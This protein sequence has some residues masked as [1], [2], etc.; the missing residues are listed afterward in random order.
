MSE[1]PAYYQ[2]EDRLPRHPSL[3]HLRNESRELQRRIRAGEP[4]ALAELA[5]HH[6]RRASDA[7]TLKLSDAQHVVARRYG[8]PSWS[9]LRRFVDDVSRLARMPHEVPLDGDL[10]TRFVRLACLT[11]GGDALERVADAEAIL[12]AHP[13][14]GTADLAA[15]AAAGNV[16]A[17]D[18]T[19]AA[20]PAA[21]AREV[22]PHRWP[23]L[24][25]AAY[26]RVEPSG[27]RSTLEV[28]RRLLAAGADPNAGYLWDGQYPFTALTGAFGGGE[29]A[30]N[31]PP[32]P[33]SS[34]LARLLLDAGAHPNDTQ[35]IY[36]RMFWPRNDHYD[37]LFEYGLPRADD[38]PWARRLGWRASPIAAALALDLEC[39]AGNDFVD[40]V[41]LL[42]AHGV[43][44]GASSGHAAIGGRSPIE[45]AER[46]GNTE[47]VRL[48]HA[49]GATSRLATL[50]P[51]AQLTAAC[52]RNDRPTAEALLR[53]DPGL[54]TAAQAQHAPVQLAA[55]KGRVDAIRLML[56][57]GFDVNAPDENGQTGLHAAAAA[58]DLSLVET[59]IGMGAD[60]AR[61]DT[62]FDG[63]P[64][65][66]AAHGH[67]DDVVAYF[68]SLPP[69]GA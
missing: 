24:L 22:G 59:L 39:A 19:L 68:D 21:V 34:A 31:Q 7:A 44:P 33:E 2:P 63:T 62:R 25:Y 42:L 67:H 37:L 23:P 30:A 17:V 64:R 5:E 54:V 61:R 57:L 11:Y 4:T 49:A 27:G 66:W 65:G 43:P 28:A 45:M 12:A 50:D 6:S 41:R 60:P 53:S 9:R 48:L 26:S 36:N 15:A 10:A 16:A 13:D 20:D 51:A 18:V 56:A 29:D 8:F 55:G 38:G 40:R 47:V 3:D 46:A 14:L 1:T 32:H 69:G 58:G 52:L 35:A